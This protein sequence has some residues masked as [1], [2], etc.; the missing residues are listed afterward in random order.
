MAAQ[1]RKK[2]NQTKSLC[3]VLYWIKDSK[4]GRLKKLDRPAEILGEEI[5][6]FDIVHAQSVISERSFTF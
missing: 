4:G 1:R 5:I 3:K 6:M 2:R